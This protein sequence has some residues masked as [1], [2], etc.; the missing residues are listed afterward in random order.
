M[1]EVRVVTVADSAPPEP[2]V[3]PPARLPVPPPP[4]WAVRAVHVA[5]WSTVPSSVWRIALVLGVPVG[6]MEQEEFLATSSRVQ[7]QRH[8]SSWL[9]RL[10]SR[11]AAWVAP[12]APERTTVVEPPRARW[13]PDGPG[14]KV[15][16]VAGVAGSS[17]G[18]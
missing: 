14:T 7:P 9:S 3:A 4:R 2:G 12:L 15:A 16:R 5:A 10:R 8:S 18:R 17:Q 6:V 11:S 13:V 1:R